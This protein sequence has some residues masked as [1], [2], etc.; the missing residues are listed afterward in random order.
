M[1]ILI[2]IIIITL[3]FIIYF[4]KSKLNESFGNL[5]D[6]A[7]NKYQQIVNNHTINDRLQINPNN[8]LFIEADLSSNIVTAQ[9]V[10]ASN[11]S[12]NNLIL[13]PN[14]NYNKFILD[15]NLISNIKNNTIQNYL[16]FDIKKNYMYDQSSVIIYENITAYTNGN[17]ASGT[18]GTDI[19]GSTLIPFKPVSKTWD[20]WSTT[21]YHGFNI[22]R[23]SNINIRGLGIELKIPLNCNVLW[24]CTLI[25]RFA[26]FKIS[27]LS[28]TTYGIYAA[29]RNYNNGLN[30]GGTVSTLLTE[31][32][33]GWIPIPLYWLDNVTDPEQRKVRLI[34]YINKSSS[35]NDNTWY[36]SKIAF[37]SNIWNHVLITPHMI[38]YDTNSITYI[39]PSQ[40]TA[41]YTSSFIDRNSEINNYVEN[42]NYANKFLISTNIN[43]RIRIPIIKSGKDKIL[44]FIS[45]NRSYNYNTLQVSFVGSNLNLIKLDNLKSTFINPF[46]Q[47]YNSKLWN[48]Y[49][50]TIIPNSL[51]TADSYGR[52]FVTLNI[53]SPSGTDFYIKEIGTHDAY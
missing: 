11:I 6:T 24:I 45:L 27:D 21:G 4:L 22:Y 9:D 41:A 7:K 18:F 46:S 23:I 28:G 40:N 19:S 33:Y 32:Y 42:W 47:Y 48:S 37:S 36:Y 38:R 12:V 10:S 8:N 50:A 44:Y 16:L 53:F 29:T 35:F 14:I 1:K 49:R 39:P 34:N 15:Y 25:D 5:V 3:I 26:S 30:P 17:D 31:N 51:I 52:T 13:K 43:F 20:Q 2:F